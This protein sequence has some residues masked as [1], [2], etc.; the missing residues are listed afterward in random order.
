MTAYPTFDEARNDLV[1]LFNAVTKK[2]EASLSEVANAAWN[3]QGMLQGLLIP[4]GPT[5]ASIE[6]VGHKCLTDGQAIT[7]LGTLLDCKES[8]NKMRAEGFFGGGTREGVLSGG[9]RGGI[10]K[11]LLP[12]ILNWVKQW[13]ESGGLTEWLNSLLGNEV[14]SEAASTCDA[15]AKGGEG[16]PEAKS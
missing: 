8:E 15:G 5:A 3:V 10:A 2:S 7:A 16:E 1:T 9:F 12:V 4:D 11:L 14:S 13:I 6:D